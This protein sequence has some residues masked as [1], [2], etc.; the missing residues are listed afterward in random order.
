MK[1]FA[2]AALA[3]SAS[4]Q[5]ATCTSSAECVGAF[6]AYSPGMETCCGQLQVA[7]LPEVA[8]PNYGGFKQYLVHGKHF[9]IMKL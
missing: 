6:D 2:L 3:G 1:F 9:Q 4:A 7:G 8:A 5:A